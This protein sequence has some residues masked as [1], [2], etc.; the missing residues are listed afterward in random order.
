[1]SSETQLI[2]VLYGLYCLSCFSLLPQ[3]AVV[4]ELFNKR[5]RI[6]FPSNRFAFG[7]KALFF[8]DPFL[9]FRPLFTVAA[10]HDNLHGSRRFNKSTRLA[11]AVLKRLIPATSLLGVLLLGVLPAALILMHHNVTVSAM[12][13]IY[14]NLVFLM[15]QIWFGRKK[16]RLDNRQFASMAF[17]YFLCPPFAINAIRNLSMPL[18]GRQGL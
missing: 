14:L 4:V 18:P 13:A 11:N 5:S 17:E 16:L 6:L 3:E 15:L 2:A 7:G 9:F 12:I 1:M 10:P 8:A